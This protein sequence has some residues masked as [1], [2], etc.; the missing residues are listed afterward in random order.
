MSDKTPEDAAEP[1]ADT[2]DDYDLDFEKEV[3][4][5]E[6]SPWLPHPEPSDGE[7]PAP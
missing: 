2:T 7:A 5:E 1:T 3:A 4:P 6:G